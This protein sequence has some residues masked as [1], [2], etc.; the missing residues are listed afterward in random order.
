MTDTQMC[1]YRSDKIKQFPTTWDNFDQMLKEYTGGGKYAMGFWRGST[2][3][4][5]LPQPLLVD[6]GH[7]SDGPGL[8]PED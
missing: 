7:H 3:H 6:P 2:G 4:R 1:W 8:E 5:T